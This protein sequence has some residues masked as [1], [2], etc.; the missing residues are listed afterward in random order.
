MSEAD[1]KTW[2]PFPKSNQKPLLVK[3]SGERELVVRKPTGCD[4]FA[5]QFPNNVGPA[6][7]RAS[8]L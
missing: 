6:T 8:G 2:Q 1:N 5:L 7:G 4:T 3:V